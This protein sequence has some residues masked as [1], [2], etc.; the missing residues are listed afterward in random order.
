MHCTA[1][2]KVEEGKGKVRNQS[3]FETYTEAGATVCIVCIRVG[4][5]KRMAI[6][7]VYNTTQFW[8][9]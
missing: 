9:K 8:C 7:S 4:R 3:V 2:R 1:A 5:Y 6:R